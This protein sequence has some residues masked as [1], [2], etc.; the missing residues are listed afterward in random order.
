[1]VDR[2]EHT[3]QNGGRPESAPSGDSLETL[4]ASAGM[5]ADAL[6]VRDDLYDEA[7]LLDAVRIYRR[8]GGRFR[9]VDSGRLDRFRLEWLLEA[10][11]DLYT[12]DESRTDLEELEGLLRAAGKGRSILSYFVRGSFPE[13]GADGETVPNP[14]LQLGRAGAY[15]HVSNRE[16]NRSPDVLLALAAEC[17]AGGSHLVIYHHGPFGPEM[18]ELAGANL[19]LHLDERSL[20]ESDAREFFLDVLKSRG[21]RAR[22]VLYSEGKSEALWLKE[23]LTAGAYLRFQG[24]QFDYRSPYKSLE[25]AASRKKLPH[26]AYFLHPTFLL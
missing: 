1:M 22:F 15:L 6:T 25:R 26:T 5:G 9:L 7:T 11:A 20:A 3:T 23:T 4:L 19:W 14:L 24:K 12:S 16:Q 21:S 13:E 10:G 8:G 17:E 18:V 2:E